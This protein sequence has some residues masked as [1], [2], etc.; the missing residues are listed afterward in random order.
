MTS[1]VDKF[2]SRLAVT[3][4]VALVVLLAGTVAVLAW[5][6]VASALHFTSRRAPAY[7]TGQRVDA[8]AE[9]YGGSKYTLILFARSECGACDRAKPFFRSLV[10]RVKATGARVVLAG[11]DPNGKPDSAFAEAIGVEA[12]D[13][14][15]S[16]PRELKVALV[17]TLLVVTPDGTIAGVWDYIGP[18][19]QYS[20]A[21]R[22]QAAIAEQIV[23]LIGG[24]L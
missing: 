2:L 1:R 4:S 11:V 15:T 14:R 6:R 18:D 12:R 23:S 3:L 17:P 19:K 7:S 5:P 9:W 21:E 20:T 8:P 24:G 13:V 22:K 16:K 10:S